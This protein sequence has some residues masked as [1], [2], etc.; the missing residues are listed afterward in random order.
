MLVALPS[1]TDV[2]AQN[3]RVV[4][5]PSSVEL[6]LEPGESAKRI[7]TVVNKGT[8]SFVLNMSAVPY[9]V[10]DED[11]GPKYTLPPGAVDASKWVAFVNPDAHVRIEPEK[12]SEV[13]YIVQVPKE[14][15][16]GGYYVALFATTTPGSTSNMV[17]VHNRVAVIQYITVKGDVEQ[18]GEVSTNSFKPVLWGGTLTLPYDVE[19]TGGSHFMVKL[20]AI[21]KT[22]WGSEVDRV[23]EERYVLPRTE[24]RVDIDWH[25]KE[26]LGIY[27]IEQS[28]Q[29]LGRTEQL[30]SRWLIIA[31]PIALI[32]LIA[33]VAGVALYAVIRVKRRH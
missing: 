27:K 25:A 18:S 23:S 30:P 29:Y 9:S 11:Y 6:E 5:S 13:G 26:I 15:K 22:A 17:V 16:P 10:R 7:L 31:Q 3:Q 1:A 20:S 24:R 28:A 2:A 4:V 21:V 19:N 14:A 12:L 32:G 33:L 8:D